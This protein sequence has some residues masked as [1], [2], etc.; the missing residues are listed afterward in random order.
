MSFIESLL[1]PKP[2]FSPM[3]FW[4][5]NG[6]LDD[7]EITRQMKDFKEHGVCGVVLHPRMGLADRIG[8]LS[9][10][11]FHYIRHALETARDLDMKVVLYDE[12][13]Y[14]SGSAGGQIV[15]E[16]PSLASRGIVRVDAPAEGDRVLCKTDKGYICE[17]F[18][19]GTIR[20]VHFGEDD[21]EANAPKSAD[22]LCPKAVARFIELTHEA[23]YRIGAE[24]FG[25]TVIGF[26]TDEPSILGR[27][28]PRGMMPWSQDFD[29]L[30]T[31]EGGHLEG[32]S[33]LFDKEENA[34]TRLYHDL[35]LKREG[36][37]YY[38]ALSAWCESHGIALMGHPHQ[39]DD[40][41][42]Q[43]YFHIPGQDLVLRWLA[44]ETT[45]DLNGMDSVMGKCSADA[46]RLMGRRRN[47]NECYGA[48]NR[49]NNPWYFTGSD[50]KWY[51]DYLAVRGVNLFIPHAFYYSLEGQRSGERPPDVGPG[52]IWWK[53][54]R[55]WG[56]Y[57]A[58]MSY[59]MT[60]TDLHA[61]V[62]VL[63]E[64]RDMPWK[65]VRPLFENQKGFM[66][67]PK[68]FW[69]D[70]KAEGGKLRLGDKIFSAVIGG[71]EAFP[72]ANRNL[73]AVPSDCGVKPACP[74][75]RLARFEKDGHKC[76]LF[77]NAGEEAIHTEVTLPGEGEIAAV[78]LW[79]GKAVR[80]ASALRPNA[81]R[82]T[83]H[84]D[85]R[86]S[87][88]LVFVSLREA[89]ELPGVSYPLILPAPEFEEIQ[90]DDD[91]QTVVYEASCLL[92]EEFRDSPAAEMTLKGE[93]MF[94]LT[95]N[96]AFCGVSFWNPHRM[97]I[98][99]GILKEGL[100]HFTLTVT[101]SRANK[102]GREKVPYGLNV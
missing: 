45:G 51:T 18:S 74:D 36:E 49:D 86:Q 54:W 59:L 37:V 89:A 6:D 91:R 81:K 42:V 100:N 61:D 70:M 44:P 21:G 28:A 14:P 62:A 17:R 94:E 46:A 63:C 102:Y 83:L 2:E 80:L 9:E 8:Y 16:D 84:L 33:A 25:S 98:P 15:R 32:L 11:F 66:Y 90:R 7:A 53:H 40:I 88:L 71:E 12:G 23:Y 85:R 1:T 52:S 96:G 5:L 47:S 50:M 22:L 3:P 76:F 29:R 35:I 58:R 41:E 48:C 68:S 97:Q 82:V 75:L 19:G 20:G 13:M 79:N 34:D 55:L 10:S 39:S 24:F 30:F 78:D 101:G 65:E 67:I 72:D 73:D 60:D 87:L 4:F 99:R 92:G 27:N 69:K 95:V 77:V 38:G 93:E 64:N 26:F 56:D 57:I 31:Q 43:R